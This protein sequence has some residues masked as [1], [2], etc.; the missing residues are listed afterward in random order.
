MVVIFLLLIVLAI[1]I[2]IAIYYW[3]SSRFN[4]FDTYMMNLNTIMKSSNSKQ[5]VEINDNKN[6]SE[7][8]RNHLID[9]ADGIQTHKI[10]LGESMSLSALQTKNRNVL[11][12]KSGDAK[13]G[14]AVDN[15]KFQNVDTKCING[16]GLCFKKKNIVVNNAIDIRSGNVH[17]KNVILKQS[18]N[19]NAPSILSVTDGMGIYSGGIIS[20]HYQAAPYMIGNTM[21]SNK[22]AAN[23]MSAHDIKG[24]KVTVDQLCSSKTGKCIDI[25]QIMTIGSPQETICSSDK[26]INVNNISM[27]GDY[28]DNLCS[29]NGENCIEFDNIATK[30]MLHLHEE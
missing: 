15:G 11:H 17:G 28:Y 5:D 2:D 3:I 23:Q 6:K 30:D 13:T 21:A 14:I 18:V 12:V 8:L 26:C 25:D 1:I 16:K 19:R 10:D 29:E 20:K 9:M 4:S 7:Q 24:D 27:K 22:M